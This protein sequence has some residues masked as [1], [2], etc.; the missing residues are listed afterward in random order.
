M[1]NDDSR[2]LKC[3]LT[4]HLLAGGWCSDCEKE[5][6]R[7]IPKGAQLLGHGIF[8][9]PK[10]ETEGSR[11]KFISLYGM[12]ASKFADVHLK[13]PCIGT[14]WVNVI[15]RG[16]TS[17]PLLITDMGAFPLTEHHVKITQDG[18]FIGSRH[19]L[20]RER[21]WMLL[22]REVELWLHEEES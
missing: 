13:D 19:G 17:K 2:C 8:A 20:N 6:K 14:L 12:D 10:K 3:G 18:Q 22:D 9:W 5:A 4:R 7:T 1:E 16:I 11:H 21:L 15:G